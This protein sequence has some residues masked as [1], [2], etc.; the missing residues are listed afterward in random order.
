MQN[1]FTLTENG[2]NSLLNISQINTEINLDIYLQL[3]QYKLL[4][5]K[6]NLFQCTLKDDTNIYD[7][8][9]LKSKKE[10]NTN[11]IIHIIKI[12][13]TITGEKKYFNCLIYEN[14]EINV[15]I[16]RLN[17]QKYEQEKKEKEQKEQKEQEEL[18][19]KKIEEEVLRKKKKEEDELKKKKI[20]EELKRKKIEEEELKKKKM[21]E[22]EELNKVTKLILYN[23]RYTAEK[24]RYNFKWEK[25]NLKYT[26][27]K[28]KLN[29]INNII[30]K[31]E[32]NY[33]LESDKPDEKDKEKDKEKEK[34]EDN[35]KVEE[36]IE[37]EVKVKN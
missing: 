27:F 18:K 9:I 14:L 13:I 24:P 34:G 19:K 25:G 32:N 3:I 17:K 37:I 36:I 8:F 6:H 21:E 2:I 35:K 11:N 26:N 22:E 4:S 1:N 33:I 12:K 20:E 28:Q 23:R 7:K 5:E 10:L 30:E 31:E 16:N 15:Y 29:D